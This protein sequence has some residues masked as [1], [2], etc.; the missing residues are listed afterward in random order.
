[1]K[2]YA[3][4]KAFATGQTFGTEPDQAVNRRGA[5]PLSLV[6]SVRSGHEEPVTPSPHATNRFNL[7]ARLNLL[8]TRFA[9]YRFHSS[10]PMSILSFCQWLQKTSGGTAIRE[11]VWQFA[12]IESIHIL[13]L[14]G[15]VGGAAV[16][17][18]RVLG[19]GTT[20]RS[21][22][23]VAKQ[24]IPVMLISFA[25]NAITGVLM[26][27]SDPLRFYR[28]IAFWIKMALLILS[29]G[30]NALIFHFAVYRRIDEWGQA[31][32]RAPINAR[33]MAIASLTIWVLIVF[34]GRGI[35]YL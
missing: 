19:I 23:Q 28:S 26:F 27:W 7:D 31:A 25:V 2:V 22:Q 9:D 20:Y 21:I 18:L 14:V 10:S 24:M 15:V 30:L 4:R 6:L 17:D 32:A 12:V 29:A 5:A 35:A 11:S 16:L 33:I 8:Q 34:A 3:W 13:A 1:M